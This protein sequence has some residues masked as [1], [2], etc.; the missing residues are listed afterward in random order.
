MEKMNYPRP[1]FIREQWLDLNGPWAFAFDD[2][3]DGVKNKLY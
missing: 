3:D 1:Q 2:Q